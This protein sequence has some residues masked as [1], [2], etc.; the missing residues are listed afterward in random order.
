MLAFFPSPCRGLL[1]GPHFLPAPSIYSISGSGFFL[2]ERGMLKNDLL[3]EKD[4][5]VFS[6]K[7]EHRRN[8]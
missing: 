5:F 1:F 7:K 2:L 4:H 6:L 3:F 8:A